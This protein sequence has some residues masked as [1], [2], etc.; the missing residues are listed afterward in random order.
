MLTKVM[1]VIFEKKQMNFGKEI[2]TRNR[3][4]N[5]PIHIKKQCHK[6]GW[7]RDRSRKGKQ[8]TKVRKFK[9]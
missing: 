1:G 5:V 9:K 2:N 8:E 4:Q 6:K 7:S 3:K